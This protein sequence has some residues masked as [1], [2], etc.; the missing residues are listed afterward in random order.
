MIWLI[1]P[2]DAWPTY[3]KRVKTHVPNSEH[4]TTS[5]QLS[6]CLLLPRQHTML[7]LH[8]A[9]VDNHVGECDVG[10]ETRHTTT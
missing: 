1:Q 6:N 5:Y 3:R 9:V 8:A 10:I 2:T 4:T 7:Y